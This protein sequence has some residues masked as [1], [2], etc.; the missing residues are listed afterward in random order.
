VADKS[1][2]VL[3]PDRGSKVELGRVF[4]PLAFG[5]TKPRNMM[6]GHLTAAEDD[7][8]K[9]NLTRL[10]TENDKITKL[11]LLALEKHER[12]MQ[13]Q[14]EFAKREKLK[15][16]DKRL[17]QFRTG[18]KKLEVRAMWWQCA[19]LP[20]CDQVWCSN[21]LCVCPACRGWLGAS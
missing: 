11:R 16:S 8:A 1:E 2:R 17:R 7:R 15:E 13:L 19:R 6:P 20:C 12:V 21:S 9:T 10:S 5:S 4:H 3:F 18:I 14:H